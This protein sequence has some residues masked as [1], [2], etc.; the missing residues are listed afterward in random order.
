MLSLLFVASCKR[1]LQELP[2]PEKTGYEYLPLKVG[3]QKVFQIDSIIFNEYTGGIDSLT[4]FQRRSIIDSYYGDDRQ[5]IYRMLIEERL[6]DTLPWV[7][8]Q[9]DKVLMNKNYYLYEADNIPTIHL[10]FPTATG[11]SWNA[12][13]LNTKEEHL[14]FYQEVDRDFEI[15]E[16]YF[17]LTLGVLQM[18]V[19]NL[20][21]KRYTFERYAKDVGFIYR[22]DI[23]LKTDFSGDT[24]SGYICNWTFLY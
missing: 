6:S 15:S 9:M 10:I 20:I 14:Y 3:Q 21:E 22:E 13:L 1:D 2:T 12:N 7:E 17:P 5:L 24:L 16:M 11:A 4:H 8:K 19:E 18:D 23:N